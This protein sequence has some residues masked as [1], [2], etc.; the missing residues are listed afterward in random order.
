MN[1]IKVTTTL[2]KSIV[3]TPK[4]LNKKIDKNLLKTFQNK[5][6]GKCISEGYVIP[7]TTKLIKRTIGFLKGSHFTGNL[8]FDVLFK[9]ELYNP[10]KDNIIECTVQRVNELG[11]QSIVGPMQIVIPKELHTDKT[12]FKDIKVGD[13]IKVKV[14]ARRFDLYD[15]VIYITAKLADDVGKIKILKESAPVKKYM[16]DSEDDITDD[17]EDLISVPD[18]SEGEEEDEAAEDS[19]DEK[20]DDTLSVSESEDA[21]TDEVEEDAQV[22]LDQEE[23]DYNS[24]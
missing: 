24:E 11:I 1:D 16:D 18:E 17:E 2:V 10:V 5:Y 23:F 22:K 15:T 20:V 13:K 4:L 14:I 6:E 9:V 19:G 21:G 8:T 12:L 3:L 7:D